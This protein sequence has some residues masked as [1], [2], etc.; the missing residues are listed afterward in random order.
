MQEE[1]RPLVESLVSACQRSTID[2]IGNLEDSVK[3]LIIVSVKYIVKNDLFKCTL[4]EGGL[5]VDWNYID[6]LKHKGTVKNILGDSTVWLKLMKF[7]D[8][9]D[10]SIP[11]TKLRTDMQPL[12]CIYNSLRS[13]NVLRSE[14]GLQKAAPSM[15]F[16]DVCKLF[17]LNNIEGILS[18]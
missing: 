18:K 3:A 15:S 10:M 8:F 5:F 1:C 14:R 16:S 9:G 2:L 12:W 4:Q 17:I 13:S 11:E 7:I 6:A